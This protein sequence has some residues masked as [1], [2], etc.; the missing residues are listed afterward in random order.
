MSDASFAP[1]RFV[2]AGEAEVEALEGKTHHWYFREGLGDADSLVF[3]RAC[4]TPGA[5]H[6]WHTHPE[7]DE[8]IYVLEGEMTQW[9]EKESRVLRPGDSI[10]IPRGVVHG[11]L[12]QSAA[13]CEFLA[14]LT[15]SKIAGP[16]AVD[17]AGQTDWPSLMGQ[18]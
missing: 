3:V 16:F 15:P 13:D 11:C 7:M 17:V 14:I 6:D 5:G 1:R 12:N 18:G 10:F 4:I 8:I 2:A 9:L